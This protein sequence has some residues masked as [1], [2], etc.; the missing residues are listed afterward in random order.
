MLTTYKFFSHDTLTLYDGNS[1]VS[2]PLAKHCGGLIPPTY[3][4]QTNMLFIHFQTDGSVTR[5]GFELEYTPSSKLY[6][7]K[8]LIKF[9]VILS[10]C[11]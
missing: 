4:S 5:T 7:N 11:H 8:I 3:F 6:L 1:E 9:D 10:V 2:P